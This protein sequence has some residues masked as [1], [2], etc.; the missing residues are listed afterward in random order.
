MSHNLHLPPSHTECTPGDEF[1]PHDQPCTRCTC[2]EE[3]GKAYKDY[4]EIFCDAPRCPAGKMVKHSPGTC[5]GFE[6]VDSGLFLCVI[7]TLLA[8]K[9]TELKLTSMI[10]KAVRMK[11]NFIFCT[12]G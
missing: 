12:K 8:F 3:D 6:C 7:Y 11:L 9:F 2:R 4:Q 5:C 10:Q 1:I